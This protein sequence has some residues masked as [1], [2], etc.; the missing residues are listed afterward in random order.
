MDISLDSLQRMSI[1]IF[2]NVKH[3]KVGAFLILRV[4]VLDVKLNL[5]ETDYG[6]FLADEVSF[7]SE[8]LMFSRLL[9]FNLVP[10]ANVL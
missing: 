4:M 8:I 2:H 9:Q 6:N 7:I 3:L 10:F 5:Q 1:V